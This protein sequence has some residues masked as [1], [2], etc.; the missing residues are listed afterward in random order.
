MK[1]LFSVE[2]KVAIV[3]GGSRG[4]GE[5]IARGLLENGVKTYITS[6][7]AED[8]EAAAKVLSEFGDCIAIAADLSTL[9]GIESFVAEFSEQESQLDFLINNAGASWGEELDQF[10]EIGWD[11][12]MDINTKS[13]FFL[14]QKLLPLLKVAGSEEDPARVV[15]IAS[16]NGIAHPHLPNYSYSA[17]KAALIQMTRHVS[18]ELLKDNINVNAIAPGFFVSKM[19]KFLVA[20][21]EKENQLLSTIPKGRLGRAEDIAGAVIYL[22]S[23]ASA[24]VVGHTMVVDGG[25]IANAG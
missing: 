23:P 21:E 12:V 19:T 5:M 14:M 17:S 25:V 3:T 8:L 15:N 20:D 24:W 22:C 1:S 9:K 4:I 18:V 7:K 11:K 13:P 2:G 10:P 16:I 6:R